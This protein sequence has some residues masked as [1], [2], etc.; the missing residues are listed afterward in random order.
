MQ[1]AVK[2]AQHFML[3]LCRP[4]DQWTESH[5]HIIACRARC[6]TQQSIYH[7]RT[8]TDRLPILLRKEDVTALRRD[9]ARLVQDL[10]VQKAEAAAGTASLAVLDRVKT[11]MEAACSTL[12]VRG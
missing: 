4:S 12:K 11:R 7:A 9:M 3:L 10:S 8:Q 6:R 2:P 5:Q 1:S